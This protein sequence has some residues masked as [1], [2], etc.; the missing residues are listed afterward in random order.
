MLL[1]CICNN[2][3]QT[4]QTLLEQPYIEMAKATGKN[5]F[6]IELEGG[7]T[8]CSELLAALVK[9]GMRISEFKRQSTGLE[10]LFM[11]ITKGD[12]Q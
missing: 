6:I 4:L 2:E 9:G 11:N 12:V 8:E 10:E 1:R 5:E 3:Q 7:D